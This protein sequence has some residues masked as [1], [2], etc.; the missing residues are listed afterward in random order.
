[1]SVA[2]WREME[3]NFPYL[4]F[5]KHMGTWVPGT[6]TYLPVTSYEYGGT[7]VPGTANPS[8]VPVPGTW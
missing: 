1:M 5:D 6:G 7:P 2:L 4:L 8:P 3:S